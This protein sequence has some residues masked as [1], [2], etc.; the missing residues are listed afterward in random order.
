MRTMTARHI[1]TACTAMAFAVVLGCCSH[2]RHVATVADTALYEV[3]SDVHAAEQTALCGK[4]SC[5]GVAPAPTVPGWTQAKS[6][7]F[8]KKLLPAVEGGR[9]LNIVLAA[10]TPGQ[11]LPAQATALIQSLSASL[12][13]VTADFPDGTTKSAILGNIGKAQAIVL[14][15]LSLALQVKGA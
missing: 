9:Q 15:I 13:A 7:A 6:T 2:P 5:A 8:N 10:W 12:A 11:P 4:A 14:N 3:L 1:A